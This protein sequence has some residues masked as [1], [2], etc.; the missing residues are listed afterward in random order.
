ME[1]ISAA[2]ARSTHRLQSLAL[3]Q[4]P[5]SAYMVLVTVPCPVL[6]ARREKERRI[7]HP[8]SRPC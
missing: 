2:L 6:L 1:R 5:Q 3:G 4:Q 8:A 7:A